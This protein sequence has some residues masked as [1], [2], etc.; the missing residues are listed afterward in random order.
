ML[1]KSVKYLLLIVF[2]ALGWIVLSG[3]YAMIL[4]G[5]DRMKKDI[6]ITAHRGGAGYGP[7][8][9]I[10]CIRRSLEA[11]I[12]SIEIDVQLSKDGHLVVCHDST[13]DRTTNGS[14]RISDLTLA[15]L[16]SLHLVSK[17]GDELE[18]GLPLLAD[19]LKLIDGKAHLL[20]EI[21]CPKEVDYKALNSAVVNEFKEHGNVDWV[22]VQSFS[23]ETLEDMHEQLP[24]M[25]LEKLAF[26]KVLWLPYIFD[27]K[28]RYFN[29][30]RYSH[31]ESLNF[32]Y[33]G[34]SQSFVE[35]LHAAGK[36]VRV[37]TLN[38]P[39]RLPNLSVDGII[40]DYP[41]LMM[42]HF[43]AESPK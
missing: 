2:F 38:K 26:F 24:T 36:R 41:D 15:E 1:K 19:V 5:T 16:K 37:W 22:T 39:A 29:T 11:G 35:A 21:K 28:F 27:G 20:L 12:P 8:N 7:E 34:I 3:V 25:R 43:N 40:T 23:D 42:S 17:E 18:E 31:V 14:G 30:E 33:G 4:F 6:A 9:S 10:S 13:V 32:F